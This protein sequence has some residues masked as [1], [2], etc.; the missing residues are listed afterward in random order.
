MSNVDK[1]AACVRVSWCFCPGQNA[2]PKFAS[3]AGQVQDVSARTVC[4]AV[5]TQNMRSF[6]KR[7]TETSR[8]LMLNTDC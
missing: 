5:V 6:T 7:S 3:I 1:P 2:K 4:Y 8:Q